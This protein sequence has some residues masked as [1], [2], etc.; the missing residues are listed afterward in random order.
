M[1]KKERY[2]KVLEWFATAM[3]EADTELTF[4]NTFELLVAVML[5]A[6]CTDKRVNMVTKGLFAAY[7]TPATMAAAKVEEVF[8]LIRSV[9]YP[10]SKAAHLVGMAQMVQERFGGTRQYGRFAVAAWGGTQDCQCDDGGGVREACHASRHACVQ[11][12][13]AHRADD[14]FAFTAGDGAGAC[15]IYTSAFALAGAPLDFVAWS[16]CVYSS[17]SEVCKMRLDEGL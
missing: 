17:D 13:G 14:A 3:P 8:A 9:S 7:P 12:I 5:S 2:S 6:Q 15:E 11:G 4:N 16:V 10:N 1:N